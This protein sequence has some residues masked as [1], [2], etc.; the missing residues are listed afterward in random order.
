[1]QGCHL[2]TEESF[3]AL[4]LWIH[5]NHI[6]AKSST[7]KMS[8]KCAVYGLFNFRV[9]RHSRLIYR[10]R[11]NVRIHEYTRTPIYVRPFRS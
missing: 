10:L 9:L 3:L 4:S 2:D 7:C 5:V 11:H 6:A 8:G 1:M